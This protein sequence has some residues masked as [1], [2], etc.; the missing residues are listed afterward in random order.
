MDFAGLRAMGFEFIE[1]DAPV[2]LDGLPAA[3]G[4]VPSSDI[5]RFLGDFGLTLI[6]GRI[7]DDWLLARV[8]GFGVLFGKGTLFGGP[9]LVKPE[10]VAEPAA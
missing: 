1:L 9:K 4:R 10:V 8:L 5:C 6:V 3:E 2:F 7:E